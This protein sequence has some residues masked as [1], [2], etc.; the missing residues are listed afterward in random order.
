[1]L[2]RGV[3]VRVPGPSDGLCSVMTPTMHPATHRAAP[4]MPSQGDAP[5]GT[6]FSGGGTDTL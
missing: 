6:L 1:M 2:S 4:D 5:A 3:A